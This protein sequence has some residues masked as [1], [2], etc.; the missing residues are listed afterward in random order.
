MIGTI[1]ENQKLTTEASILARDSSRFCHPKPPQERRTPVKTTRNNVLLH[2]IN[3]FLYSFP[4]VKS[5][6]SDKN[7][8]LSHW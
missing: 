2:P 3:L 4:T 6:F 1:Q 8:T 7:G 5:R